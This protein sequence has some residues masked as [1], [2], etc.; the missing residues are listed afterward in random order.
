[1]DSFPLVDTFKYHIYRVISVC[2]SPCGKYICSGSEDNTI[3]LWDIENNRKEPIHIFK[4]HT[5]TV[6][7]VCF[8]PCGKYICSGSDDKT[9]KLWDIKPGE[10]RLSTEGYIDE[11]GER[12]QSADTNIYKECIYTFK[13]HTG[14]L[15]CICFSPCGKFICSGSDDKSIKIWNIDSRKCI[16]TFKGHDYYVSSVCF[17]PC[18]N[19]I[20][21]SSWDG[22]IKLWDI[23]KRINFWNT[24]KK[25]CILTFQEHIYNVRS[26][27][28]SPCGKYICS[29]SSDKFIKLWD[30]EGVSCLSS[31]RFKGTSY[32]ECIHI[33]EGH[34]EWVTSVCFSPCGN[35]ICS[36]SGDNTVKLW[37]IDKKEC[38][39]T[40]EGHTE[41]VSSICFSPCGKYLCSGS[42]DK[43]IKLW[44]ISALDITPYKYN[45][46]IIVIDDMDE[47]FNSI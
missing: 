9:I 17:S 34:K 38:I 27:C 32:K 40:F 11:S 29:G 23:N 43:T 33:F 46:N 26:V 10:L 18:G 12:R 21:S 39:H 4:G 36:S 28:F 44:D 42:W 15:N 13:G 37:D 6:I 3:I 1:M 8:S 25:K 24:N 30:I 5:D 45:K 14:C 16:Y 47:F 2:F 19:Y 20:C 35:F 7:S 22:T 31:D 41:T